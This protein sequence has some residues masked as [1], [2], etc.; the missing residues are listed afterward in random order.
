MKTPRFLTGM[1]CAFMGIGLF[2]TT[3][4]AAQTPRPD[5]PDE[6]RLAE[7]SEETGAIAS[8]TKI[9]SDCT[10]DETYGL[11]LCPHAHPAVL[12]QANPE[13]HARALAVLNTEGLLLV[14][15]STNLRVMAFD[16][17]TGDL[18]DPNFIPADPMNMDLPFNAIL[19]PNGNSILVSDQNNDVILEYDFNG[20]FAGIFAPIGGA[21]ETILN[22][23]RGITLAPNGNLLITTTDDNVVQF[24]TDGNYLGEFISTT[25]AGIPDSPYDIFGRS[26][27]W[28]VT[29][30]L[31]DAVHR[32]DLSG[33]YLSD[34]A[35]VSSFPEQVTVAANGNVLVA[36]FAGDLGVLEF[37]PAG[38]LANTHVVT[39][40]G[41]AVGVRGV[42]ELPNGNILAGAG[43]I[44]QGNL[45]EIDRN[46]A[47]VTG[48]PK[49]PPGSYT[50]R[51]IEFVTV[52]RTLFLP[53][54]VR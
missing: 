29:A 36:N 21:N 52:P 1:V 4:A 46:T 39:V 16:P 12:P 51:Y 17:E 28:L 27:D 8:P 24:D 45:Y 35:P 42:Y 20:S 23:P 13:E 7:I 11:Y 19:S 48:D 44:N 37:T 33:S 38:V 54:V 10:F 43:S 9:S 18:V 22:N 15:D 32:F 49:L 26:G 41:S 25:N 47:V 40:T 30:A 34:L 50:P 6:E 14:P 2:V 53:L 31:G 5:A 3:L